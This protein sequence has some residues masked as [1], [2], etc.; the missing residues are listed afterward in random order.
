MAAR[1]LACASPHLLV[2][3]VARGPLN[4]WFRRIKHHSWLC[5]ELLLNK[6]SVVQDCILLVSLCIYTRHDVAA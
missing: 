3:L 4:T 5:T 2:P 6:K 1:H